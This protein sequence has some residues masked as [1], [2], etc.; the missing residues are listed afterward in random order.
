MRP[1]ADA[2]HAPASGRTLR[3]CVLDKTASR[4]P[5]DPDTLD[6]FFVIDGDGAIYLIPSRVVGGMTAISVG[7]YQ[8]YLVG[9]ASDCLGSSSN[10]EATE[11]MRGTS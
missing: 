11:Q 5:Y 1:F 10:A 9:H 3:G 2:V 6:Y 8:D 7:A 4:I